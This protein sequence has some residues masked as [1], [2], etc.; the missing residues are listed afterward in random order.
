[1]ASAACHAVRTAG[2]PGAPVMRRNKIAR[3]TFEAPADLHDM[4]VHF[5]LVVMAAK[6]GMAKSRMHRRRL[7]PSVPAAML[8]MVRTTSALCTPATRP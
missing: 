4:P 7:I 8:F 2:V 5:L 3:H 6:G 1:M